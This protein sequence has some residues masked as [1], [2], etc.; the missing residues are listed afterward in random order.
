MSWRNA[1]YLSQRYLL[2]VFF[3][4]IVIGAAKFFTASHRPHFFETCSPDKMFNCTLRAL[5]REFKCTNTQESF[6]NI[7]DA[8]LSF[9]SGHASTCVFACLFVCWYLQQ[10]ITSQSLFF[11]PFVQTS[12]VCLAVFGSMSRV[13]DHRHHWWD[14][15]TGVIVGVLTSYHAVC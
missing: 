9:F 14:V 5:V 12:L 2:D 8:S 10:R 13:L 6:L 7:R 4:H 15:L 11:V 1:A 3:M